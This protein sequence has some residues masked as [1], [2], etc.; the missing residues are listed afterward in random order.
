MFVH[1]QREEKKNQTMPIFVKSHANCGRLSS[2]T[3]ALAMQCNTV[4]E[5]NHHGIYFR[6]NI[7]ERRVSQWSP[8]ASLLGRVHS[9]PRNSMSLRLIR[10]IRVK[11]R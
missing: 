7:A 10:S 2:H 5:T 8:S 11:G 3:C 6:L 4:V 1:E 9:I